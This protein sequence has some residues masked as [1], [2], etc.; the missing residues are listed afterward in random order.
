MWPR[1]DPT[2]HF[3]TVIHIVALVVSLL[4]SFRLLAKALGGVES[5]QDEIL[6]MLA[7]Y[8]PEEV[9]GKHQNGRG[10]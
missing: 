6:R 10:V 1:L 5:K 7:R 2:I 4:Y 3:G 9:D 8:Y